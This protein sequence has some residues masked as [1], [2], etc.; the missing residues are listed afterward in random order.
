MKSTITF[1]L[2]LLSTFE[3][4]TPNSMCVCV[5]LRVS[6][7]VLEAAQVFVAGDAL[8]AGGG[9]V[10]RT[11]HLGMFFPPHLRRKHHRPPPQGEDHHRVCR[12][13]LNT[14]RV[15]LR[16]LNTHRVYCCSVTTLIPL[17]GVQSS[18]CSVAEAPSETAWKCWSDRRQWVW[19][20]SGRCLTRSSPGAARTCRSK[21]S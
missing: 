16:S 19:V 9:H 21:R 12:C 17:L 7:S 4:Q 10:P 3:G 14:H 18:S 11:R 15:C 13:S 8:A 2:L 5:C 6:G 1:V 20:G